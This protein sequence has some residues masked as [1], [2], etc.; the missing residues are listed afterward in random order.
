LW[1]RQNTVLDL[2][3]QRNY[4]HSYNAW[5][6]LSSKPVYWNC[7]R[8][9]LGVLGLFYWPAGRRVLSVKEISAPSRRRGGWLGSRHDGAQHFTRIS[10]PAIVHLRDWL[11]FGISAFFST[12]ASHIA[13]AAQNLTLPVSLRATGKNDKCYLS[14]RRVFLVC[15][16]PHPALRKQNRHLRVALPLRLKSLQFIDFR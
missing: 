13:T 11:C 1:S 7:R 16:R 14:S 5:H 3:P 15:R 2:S 8:Y 6:Y 9:R 12:F 10:S 4:Y